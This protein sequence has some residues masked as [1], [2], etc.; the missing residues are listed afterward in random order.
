M[1]ASAWSQSFSSD[2]CSSVHVVACC[3]VNTRWWFDCTATSTVKN[4]AVFNCTSTWKRE[5]DGDG[6]DANTFCPLPSDNVKNRLPVSTAR[7][8]VNDRPVVVAL[9][10]YKAKLLCK[11]R[12]SDG[13][14][15][16]MDPFGSLWERWVTWETSD[17]KKRCV[18][19]RTLRLV[20]LLVSQPV[21]KSRHHLLR[22][23]ALILK[24]QGGHVPPIFMKE[25][26]L[27]MSPPIL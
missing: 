16:R 15:T 23:G 10:V 11:L 24:G 5:D 12:D 9:W 25:T 26:S 17:E 19:C 1:S 21:S 2:R 22:A 8:A 14:V 7:L 27:V 4:S 18:N 20:S 3:R 6:G 13:T